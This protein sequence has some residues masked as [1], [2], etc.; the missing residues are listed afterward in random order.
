MKDVSPAAHKEDLQLTRE[1]G[2]NEGGRG[3]AVKHRQC[4]QEQKLADT[5]ETGFVG[6]SA[7]AVGG[8][9]GRK[10]QQTDG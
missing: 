6:P 3:P 10:G 8:R 9:R 5:E 4:C 7:S 1:D 2:G